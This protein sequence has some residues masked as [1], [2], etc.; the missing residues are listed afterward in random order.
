MLDFYM[1]FIGVK[2]YFYTFFTTQ[3]LFLWGY[4]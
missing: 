1:K 2:S 3:M 4:L